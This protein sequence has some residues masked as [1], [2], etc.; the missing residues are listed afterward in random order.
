MIELGALLLPAVPLLVLLVLLLLGRYPGAEAVVRLSE[1]IAARTADRHSQE[2]ALSRLPRPPRSS[3]PA[4]GLLIAL[5]PAQRPPP[6]L[7]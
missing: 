1:Q 4:G 3:A 5:G 2:P 7:V 6:T